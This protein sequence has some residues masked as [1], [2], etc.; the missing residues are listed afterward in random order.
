MNQIIS[1][2]LLVLLII[3]S[4]FLSGKTTGSAKSIIP[5][6][7]LFTTH[8]IQIFYDNSF[9]FKKLLAILLP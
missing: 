8:W 5:E 9:L 4:Y 7:S 1:K 2:H 3:I 6:S